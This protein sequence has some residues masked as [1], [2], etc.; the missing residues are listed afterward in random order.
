[1]K[2]LEKMVQRRLKWFIEVNKN[3][4]ISHSGLQKGR[5]PVDNVI[6]LEGSDRKAGREGKTLI[7]AQADFQAAFDH[8]NRHTL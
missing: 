8:V 5:S 3:C 2:I 6:L 7:A 4:S 1:V